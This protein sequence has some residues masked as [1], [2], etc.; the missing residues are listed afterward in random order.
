VRSRTWGVREADPGDAR[1]HVA[2]DPAHALWFERGILGDAEV[3]VG[4]SIG[5]IKVA[6]QLDV[7]R[8]A[9]GKPV[10]VILG[11]L[12][13]EVLAALLAGPGEPSD[14]LALRCRYGELE[15]LGFAEIA[16]RDVAH[17]PAAGGEPDLAAETEDGTAEAR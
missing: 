15:G 7:Q 12:S 2:F 11:G 1:L 10:K 5:S 14:R 17:V 3:V 8:D 16:V 13:G 6:D 4:G 9:A